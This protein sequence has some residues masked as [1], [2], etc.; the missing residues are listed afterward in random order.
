MNRRCFSL[1]KTVLLVC[2]VGCA[3]FAYHLAALP[4]EAHRA[5]DSVRQFESHDRVRRDGSG[6][7]QATRASIFSI[8]ADYFKPTPENFQAAIEEPNDVKTTPKGPDNDVMPPPNEQDD[9]KPP[10]EVPDDIKSPPKEPDDVKPPLKESDSVKPPPKEPDSVKPPPKAPLTGGKRTAVIIMTRMR[11]GSTFVGEIF[12]QHPEAFYVFEPI[13]A[14]EH[15]RNHTYNSQ[16]F[17]YEWLRSLSDCRFQGVQDILNYY[18]TAKGL[19][20]MATCNSINGL[21]AKYRNYTSQW[22]GRCPIPDD[23]MATVVGNACLSKKF[24]AIKTIRLEDI[25]P[26]QKIAQDAGIDLKVIQLVRDPRGVIAS[27]LSLV[28]KNVSVMTAL[29]SKV[30]EKE[31]RELCNWM[32]RNRPTNQGTNSW[33]QKHY[34]LLRYEDAGRNP[35]GVMKKLYKLI[36]IPAHEDVTKWIHSHTKTSKKI[37][38]RRDPFGTKKDPNITMNEWRTKL[39]FE[40]VKKIQSICKEAIDMF[41]YQ[42]VE[43]ISELRNS[44]RNFHGP[45][46][47]LLNIT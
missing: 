11:S 12:N 22:P 8:V 1:R 25:A 4:Y 16:H 35:L 6:Q 23:K 40:D 13:W 2:V 15:H 41:G 31:V 33:L 29:H 7:P 24:T 44:T 36:D 20:V 45:N 21:C 43:S 18:L 9:V 42:N 46:V 26:L 37:K 27:R 32:T 5:D 3:T 47:S 38:E 17:Q 19:G 14:L 10:L 30:D 28:H 39:S 34:A